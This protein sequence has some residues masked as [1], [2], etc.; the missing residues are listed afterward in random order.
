[1]PATFAPDSTTLVLN[2]VTTQAVLLTW[3]HRPGAAPSRATVALPAKNAYD[4]GNP[5]NYRGQT[6]VVSVNGTAKMTGRVYGQ[7]NSMSDQTVILTI[8]DNRWMINRD[9]VGRSKLGAG[10]GLYYLGADV[11]FNLGGKGNKDKDTGIYLNPAVSPDFVYEKASGGGTSPSCLDTDAA[12]WTYG[13]MI[14]WL[15]ETFITDVT[16]PTIPDTDDLKTEA[17]ELD[18]F[19]LPIGEALDRVFAKTLST[20]TLDGDGNA[21]IFS[22]ANPKTVRDIYFKNPATPDVPTNYTTDYPSQWDVINSIENTITDVNVVGGKNL[23]E[24]TASG[25]DFLSPV[26]SKNIQATPTPPPAGEAM[27][28]QLVY[29]YWSNYGQQEQYRHKLSP[30]YYENHSGAGRRIRAKD[31]YKPIFNELMIKRDEDGLYVSDDSDCGIYGVSATETLASQYTAGAQVNADMG[32]I[33]ATYVNGST[34]NATPN[35][36]THVVETE[37]RSVVT[38][39]V[40]PVGMP[41]HVYRPVL[42]NELAHKSRESGTKIEIP[43]DVVWIFNALGQSTWSVT[44]AIDV[45]TL[46]DAGGSRNYA[47]SG[48]GNFSFSNF[49]I[50]M[51]AGTVFDAVSALQEVADELDSE[52][53]RPAVNIEGAFPTMRDLELG[54]KFRCV[55]SNAYGSTGEEIVVAISFKDDVQALTF[56][57]T[58]HIGADA[59]ELATKFIDRRRFSRL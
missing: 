54:D 42:R 46:L 14:D 40:V 17:G 31:K 5:L 18:V 37:E 10:N 41:A 38:A 22:L 13:D 36:W 59:L 15:W 47:L 52:I 9:W 1:M 30:D 23:L 56:A 39:T 16:K 19:G 6:A 24:L 7:R 48:T 49:T 55:P 25:A 34:G 51:P 58:N 26:Q 3:E 2:G 33:L 8:L 12:F 35:H 43:V 29:I 21:Y 53:G 57:A 20:W 4:W 28:G 11:V 27:G 44:E 50:S 45:T 32:E